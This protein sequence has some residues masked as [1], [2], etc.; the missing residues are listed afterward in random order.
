MALIVNIYSKVYQQS[1]GFEYTKLLERILM[2][3]RLSG[4]FFHS[5][6]FSI[7]VT[8]QEMAHVAI[9]WVIWMQFVP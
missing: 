5:I 9:V 2:K 7:S 8:V 1:A 3:L 6:L 4:K